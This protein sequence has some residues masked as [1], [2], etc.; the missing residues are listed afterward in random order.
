MCLFPVYSAY[1]E[2]EIDSNMCVGLYPICW[3]SIIMSETFQSEFLQKK[4]L[5]Y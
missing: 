3:L 1:S 5:Y 4:C 2:N